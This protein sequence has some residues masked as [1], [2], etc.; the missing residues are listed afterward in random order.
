MGTW[1]REER[2]KREMKRARWCVNTQEMSKIKEWLYSG[3]F[4]MLIGG[5]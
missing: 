2:V 1:H 3:G 5:F 4:W